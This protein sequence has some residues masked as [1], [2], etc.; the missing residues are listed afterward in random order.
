M[1]LFPHLR[2]SSND[3]P[4]PARAEFNQ[5]ALMRAMVFQAEEERKNRSA[6]DEGEQVEKMRRSEFYLE[7]LIK[8]KTNE[9]Q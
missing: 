6:F 5:R 1:V 4:P 7:K 2:L 8:S 3:A 9:L